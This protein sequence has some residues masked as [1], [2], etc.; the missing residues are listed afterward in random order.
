MITRLRRPRL[1]AKDRRETIRYRFSGIHNEGFYMTD[2]MFL[3]GMIACFAVS[4]SIPNTHAANDWENEQVIAINKE[5][6]R[7]TAHPADTTDQALGQR[8]RSPYCRS[9]NGKWRFR[10]SADVSE[11]PIG[12]H[13][14]EFDDGEWDTIDVP[15]CWQ[16]RGYGT[17][18]YTNIEYPFKKNPP[19]V[20]RESGNPVG[21][22][23]K[24]F[25]VP[26]AWDGRE[27]FVHFDGVKAGFYL[28]VNGQKVGYSQGSATD[29]EFNITKHV[30]AGDNLIA[31]EVFRWTDGS[32]LEDQDGWRMSGIYREVYLLS[33]PKVHVRDFFVT[34]DLDGEYR[35]ATL[36][37]DVKVRNLGSSTAH[38]TSLEAI[39]LGPDGKKLTTLHQPVETVQPGK[40]KTVRLSGKVTN[41]R[42]WSHE[43]PNLYRFALKLKDGRSNTIEVVGCR[44]GFREIE[45]RNRQVLLNG[46]PV[47]FKGVNRV[48]HDLDEGKTVPLATTI[49]D[50]QLFKQNNINCVRTA[51]Y[52]HDTRFYDLCDEYGILVINEAN[53]ES[54]GM[55]YGPDSLAKNPSWKDAHV[56]RAVAMIERDKN[57][58]SVVMWSHG[59]EAG[60]GV[61]IVAMDDA[62][63][64]LDPTRPTHYHFDGEPESCDVLGGRSNNPNRDSGWNHYLNLSTL[65][66]HAKSGAPRPFLLN[67]YAHAMGNSMGNLAEYQ[68]MF[69]KHPNLIGGCIWDWADQGLWHTKS[70][71]RFIAYGGDFG[72]QPNSGNFCLNGVVMS[73]R[74]ETG[75]LAECKKV[76]QDVAFTLVNQADGTVELHN[77]HLFSDLSGYTLDWQLLENGEPLKQGSLGTVT[78]A[79]QQRKTIKLP[80]DRAAFRTGREY[81]VTLSLRLAADRLW[82]KRG[83]EQAWEQFVLQPK[84]FAKAA[85]TVPPG[86]VAFKETPQQIVATAGAC[87]VTFDKT[88]GWITEY[89]NA[90]KVLIEG[91]RGLHFWRAPTDNDGRF[92]NNRY[93]GTWYK[94]GLD[95]LNT[96]VTSIKIH[97]FGENHVQLRFVYDISAQK[98]AWFDCHGTFDVFADG[99]VKIDLVI[100]PKGKNQPTSLPRIGVQLQIPEGL[101]QFTWYGRGPWHSYI[102]RKHGVK[103]GL[104]SGTIDD[105][106]VN[107]PRPQENGNKT[108]VRWLGVTDHN[109]R[110]LKVIGL[111]PFE[112][113]IHHYETANLTNAWHTY[114]LNKTPHSF[115]NI[116]YRN[117][118]LGNASCGN[119]PPLD[120]YKLKPDSARYGFVIRPTDKD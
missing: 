97:R 93:A 37:V 35:N 112:A 75:K 28:W 19:L 27:V 86:K 22:Y 44:I 4:G 114:E 115:L 98:Q 77:K 64:R 23:R 55:R 60:N 67:E 3:F 104:Y 15:S 24:T 5:P 39:V 54:H 21:S 84:D 72:D 100:Q 20:R 78:V 32:Y 85:V 12:F 106:F 38:G 66:S 41:P 43:Q 33:K 94:A 63:R 120:Q 47:M 109:G 51:H 49:R 65:E 1:Y 71:Q 30:I 45:V 70:G 59:N 46:K 6:A 81:I 13:K 87:K 74:S 119:V 48:E 110:G 82:A 31:V 62:A 16:M 57:H 111:Q 99:S 69:D 88:T 52:P 10:W 29:A 25:T 7:A 90:K 92:K 14:M 117:G 76:F 80:I 79:P 96:K 68:A 40:E 83:F 50:V 36:T 56:A 53:V 102:D 58:P 95:Q 18:I 11:R 73:D 105:Q 17:P 34:T 42:K 26:G 113:S 108:D 61:N 89:A 116:D 91:G 118:P 103:L 9:L 8:E 107:Y 2:H 101:E